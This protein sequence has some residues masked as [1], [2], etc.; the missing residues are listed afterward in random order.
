[1]LDADI[2]I[3]K[4]VAKRY[5]EATR[6]LGDSRVVKLLVRIRDHEIYHAELFEELLDELKKGR[7]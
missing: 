6:E 2:R 3:E 1:M 5:D 4:Q 7:D